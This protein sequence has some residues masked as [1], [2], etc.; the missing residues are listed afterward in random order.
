MRIKFKTILFR[1]ALFVSLLLYFIPPSYGMWV[2]EE[3]GN[4]GKKKT[5][6]TFSA[7]PITSMSALEGNL[8]GKNQRKQMGAELWKVAQVFNPNTFD[9]NPQMDHITTLWEKAAK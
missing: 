8:K 4:R 2:E 7:L 6:K 1:S 9:Q 3:I 5:L